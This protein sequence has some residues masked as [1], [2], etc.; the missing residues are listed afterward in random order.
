MSTGGIVLSLVVLQGYGHAVMKRQSGDRH[1]NSGWVISEE[2]EWTVVSANEIRARST[3][4]IGKSPDLPE[5]MM[6][7]LPFLD[8]T[9]QGAKWEDENL[10]FT[11]Q[12]WLP[13][14]WERRGPYPT[15]FPDRV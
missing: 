1:L 3:L 13:I 5:Y 11:R 4:V 10:P 9:I 7:Q 12:L 2:A 6:V 15:P 14:H 8:A